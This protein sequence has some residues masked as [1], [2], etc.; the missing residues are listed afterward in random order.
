MPLSRI[1]TS[2]K[3]CEEHLNAVDISDSAGIEI[4]SLLV[5]SLVLKIVSEY[6]ELIEELFF[7]RAELSG[8]RHVTNFVKNQIAR[9]FRSPDMNKINTTLGFFDQEYKTRFMNATENS[10]AHAAW[11][12]IMRARHAI[13]HKQDNLNIT[14]RELK[15]SYNSTKDILKELITTL[16][17]P[18][19]SVPGL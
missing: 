2:I 18:P 12:N 9:K 1:E 4:E 8:D 6:E 13:V 15:E 19:E 11:D 17:L 7:K 16:G 5:S 3:T 10:P 14:F